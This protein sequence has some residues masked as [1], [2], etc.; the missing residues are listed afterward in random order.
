MTVMKKNV[1][2]TTI[3]IEKQ[4]TC[5]IRMGFRNVNGFHETYKEKRKYQENFTP[6]PSCQ[7]EMQR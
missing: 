6:N 4:L 2:F 5:I 7:T 1:Y 3:F